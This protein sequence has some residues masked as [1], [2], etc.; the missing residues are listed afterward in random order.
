MDV[1]FLLRR[2]A[3]TEWRDRHLFH[4]VS[5]INTAAIKARID[6]D[7]LLAEAALVDSIWDPS[8]FVFGRIDSLMRKHLTGKLD[9]FLAQA[10]EEL[11]VIEARFDLLAEA[12]TASAS[13][14]TFPEAAIA[15]D[16]SVS[17]AAQFRLGANYTGGGILTNL[18]SLSLAVRDHSLARTA[19][20]WSTRASKSVATRAEAVGKSLHDRMGLYDRLRRK[21]AERIA[22][23]WMGDVGSPIP[24]KAQL[25]VLI[26]DVASEARSY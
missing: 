4:A 3:V 6:F 12:L 26:D 8:G 9:A 11:R 16:E 20:A 19:R 21:A 5:T 23:A 1:E 17:E 24:L 25:L 15:P 7:A 13:T 2:Q 10:A 14:L 22:T 18:R